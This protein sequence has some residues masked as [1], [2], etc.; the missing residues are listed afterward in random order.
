MVV[1]PRAGGI[2]R[3]E[4]LGM[5][6]SGKAAR[7]GAVLEPEGWPVEEALAEAEVSTA[8]GDCSVG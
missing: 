1:E 6:S 8:G 2:E 5:T 7:A 3:P 4:V